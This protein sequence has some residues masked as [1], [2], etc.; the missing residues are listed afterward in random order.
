VAQDRV[1]CEHGNKTSVSVKDGDF[2]IMVIMIMS[3]G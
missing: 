3:M 1:Q 2:M